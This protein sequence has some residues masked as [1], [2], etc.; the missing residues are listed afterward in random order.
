[1]ST[2][3]TSSGLQYSVYTKI[4]KKWDSYDQFVAK[5]Q[6]NRYK[7]CFFDK[8]GYVIEDESFINEILENERN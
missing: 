8:D 5:S 7:K 1:M 3:T 4:D 2:K 6:L